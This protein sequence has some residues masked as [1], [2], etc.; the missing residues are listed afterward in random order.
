M[1]RALNSKNNPISHGMNINPSIRYFINY[2]AKNCFLIEDETFF[3]VLTWYLRESKE[4][5]DSS[6]TTFSL[7]GIR[8]ASSVGRAPGS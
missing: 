3:T 2:S 1:Y 8:L 4:V 7:I 6:D 5:A